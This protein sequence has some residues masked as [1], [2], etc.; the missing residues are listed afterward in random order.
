MQPLRTAIAGLG[1]WGKYITLRLADSPCFRVTHGVE[2]VADVA[3]FARANGLK[4]C[5]SPLKLLKT[6][7]SV[8]AVALGAGS[9]PAPPEG[10]GEAWPV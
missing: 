3:E 5:R 4:L 1:W 6:R 2:P 9:A 8:R 7:F 10:E